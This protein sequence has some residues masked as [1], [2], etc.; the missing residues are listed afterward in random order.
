MVISKKSS[1]S[2]SLMFK[3]IPPFCTIETDSLIVFKAIRASLLTSRKFAFFFGFS[4]FFRQKL[5]NQF[6][7]LLHI[8]VIVSNFVQ[9]FQLIFFTFKR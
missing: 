6:V 4:S 3:S 5:T 1:D 2:C 8:Q 9:N 7:C